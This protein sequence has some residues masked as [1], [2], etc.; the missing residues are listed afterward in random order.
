MNDT[1]EKE[2]VS[3]ASKFVMDHLHWKGKRY[4]TLSDVQELHIR[5]FIADGFGNLSEQDLD[6][7]M[8]LDM[9]WDWS[10]VRDSSDEAF[11]Q[12]KKYIEKK[13]A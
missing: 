9:M 10:H 5:Y 4:G 7:E 11:E 12:I 13:D 8:I 3:D 1:K 2:S 6:Q